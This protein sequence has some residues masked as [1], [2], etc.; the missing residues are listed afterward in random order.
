MTGEIVMRKAGLCALAGALVFLVSVEG[1]AQ[2]T[3][4]RHVREAVRNYQAAPVGREVAA[5]DELKKS[6][7]TRAFCLLWA[8][9]RLTLG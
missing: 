9:Q 6:P 5:A 8:L 1:W 3:S 4:T 7:H 2:Y